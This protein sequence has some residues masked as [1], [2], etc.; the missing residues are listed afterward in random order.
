MYWFHL[1]VVQNVTTIQYHV[2]ILVFLQSH[3]FRLLIMLTIQYRI[4]SE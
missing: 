1:I 4:D 3:T 2:L